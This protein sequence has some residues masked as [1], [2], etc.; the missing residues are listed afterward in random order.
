MAA[1]FSPR[2]N[3]QVVFTLSAQLV[4]LALQNKKIIYDP[5]A[6]NAVLGEA[7]KPPMMRVWSRV[8]KTRLPRAAYVAENGK[9]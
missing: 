7:T 1:N 6:S 8:P 4:P 3:V 9:P 2:P 5:L